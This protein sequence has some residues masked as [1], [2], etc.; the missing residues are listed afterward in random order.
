MNAGTSSN[1]LL[2][3]FI[4]QRL[5]NGPSLVGV[6]GSIFIDELSQINV[7][8]FTDISRMSCKRKIIFDEMRQT[9]W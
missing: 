8:E 7:T 5:N 4:N 2:T 3:D 6:S 9:P 1:R